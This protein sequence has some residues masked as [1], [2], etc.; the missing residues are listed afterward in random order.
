MITILTFC[1]LPLLTFYL[2]IKYKNY[3]KFY[4][5]KSIQKTHTGYVP[6]LGGFIIMS[7]FMIIIFI[8]N[9]KNIAFFLNYKILIAGFLIGLLTL[10]EDLFGNTSPLSR[11]IIIFLCS[12]FAIINL[13]K[14]PQINIFILSLFL[15]N[16]IF[17]IIFYSF[18]LT[19]LANGKNIIDGMNGLA[20]LTSISSLMCMLLIVYYNNLSDL[21]ILINILI[22]LLI[23]FLIFNFPYGKIFLGDSGAYWLGWIIGMFLIIIISNINFINPWIALVILFY[24]CF[25]LFFSFVRKVLQKKSPLNADTYHLHLLVHKY[26]KNKRNGAKFNNAIVTIILF[27]IWFSNLFFI[28]LFSF[29]FI[30][31]GLIIIIQILTY[32]SFYIFFSLKA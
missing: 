32:L 4:N 31:I 8:L 17:E 29:D 27:P 26:I 18:S 3:F 20:A 12:I 28:I 6:R 23:I 5:Y 10:K 15:K 30:S 25:E 14:L 19:I 1:I 2:V 24:P 22:G 13:E 16:Y 11:L 21:Y 7:Y 9:I